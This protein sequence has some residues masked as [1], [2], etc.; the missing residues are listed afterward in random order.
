MKSAP[1]TTAERLFPKRRKG[2]ETGMMRTGQDGPIA[3]NCLSPNPPG[4][5]SANREESSRNLNRIEQLV[6]SGMKEF[7]ARQSGVYQTA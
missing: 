1:A 2:G 6:E 7:N 3:T 4:W 5:T